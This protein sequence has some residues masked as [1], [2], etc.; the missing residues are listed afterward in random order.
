MSLLSMNG[1]YPPYQF[2]GLRRLIRWLVEYWK[3]RV[4]PPS[5]SGQNG[6]YTDQW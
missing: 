6:G 2:S 5:D 1:S 4:R 3:Q